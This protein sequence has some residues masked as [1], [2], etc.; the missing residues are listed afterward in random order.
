MKRELVTIT[1]VVAVAAVLAACGNRISIQPEPTSGGGGSSSSSS[2]TS[3]TSS[4]GPPPFTKVV[5]AETDIAQYQTITLVGDGT[6]ATM[7]LLDGPFFVTD[8]YDDDSMVLPRLTVVQGGDCSVD[9]NMHTILLAPAQ[10]TVGY[11]ILQIHGIRMPVLP[12]QTLCVRDT[13]SLGNKMT[14]MGFRPY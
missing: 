4:S 6:G 3:S 2:S 8:V 14:V 9:Q 1:S 5:T 12:G 10:T 13:P 7:K 11:Q